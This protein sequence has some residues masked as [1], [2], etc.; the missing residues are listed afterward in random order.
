[1][2]LVCSYFDPEECLYMSTRENR[3]DETRWLRRNNSSNDNNTNNNRISVAPC[4]G[5]T[6]LSSLFSVCLEQDCIWLEESVK[7][8]VSSRYGWP[9]SNTIKY[10]N[11]QLV[12]SAFVSVF[13]LRKTLTCLFIFVG[14]SP[15]VRYYVLL[16]SYPMHELENAPSSA[17]DRFII[18]PRVTCDG[19]CGKYKGSREGGLG[20]PPLVHRDTPL[21]MLAFSLLWT[22]PKL[23][24]SLQRF[25]TPKKDRQTYSC[26]RIRRRKSWRIK[27]KKVVQC[28]RE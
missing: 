9:L 16:R 10:F 17:F 13:G 12:V 1:M 14:Y 23:C 4:V 5:L 27:H 8:R 18:L 25:T 28:L 19:R 26:P 3:A 21:R 11:Q 24:P 15:I 20:A 6:S 7:L 2:W 22:D